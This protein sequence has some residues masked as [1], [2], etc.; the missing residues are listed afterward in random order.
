MLFTTTPCRRADREAALSPTGERNDLI[1]RRTSC[2]I[3]GEG[4]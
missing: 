2:A 3:R 1:D 4:A